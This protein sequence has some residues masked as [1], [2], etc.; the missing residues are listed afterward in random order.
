MPNM[1]RKLFAMTNSGS[2]PKELSFYFVLWVKKRPV[3]RTD[4]LRFVKGM[5]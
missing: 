3:Q 4:S 5:L 1:K 2:I